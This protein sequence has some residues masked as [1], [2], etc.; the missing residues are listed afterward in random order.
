MGWPD[1]ISRQSETSTLPLLD[2]PISVQDPYGWLRDD[3]RESKD[4]LAHLEHENAYTQAMTQHLDVLREEIYKELLEGIQETDY[5]VPRPM[6]GYWYYSR[7]G[8]GT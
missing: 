8:C 5:S 6:D 1:D 2:P 4:V 3:E 7:H